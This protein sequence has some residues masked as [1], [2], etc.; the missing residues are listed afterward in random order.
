VG[1]QT[2]TSTSPEATD[3]HAIYGKVYLGETLVNYGVVSFISDEKTMKC[4]IFP[5]GT[6]NIRNPPL[7]EYRIVIVTG[8][9]PLA[10]GGGS[11]GKPPPVLKK[12]TIPDKYGSKETTDMKYKVEKEGRFNYDIKMESG[13]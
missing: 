3:P 10:A 12:I 6:Y 9:V 4:V 7:G 1:C 8:A 5:D 13:K 2:Q 11:S